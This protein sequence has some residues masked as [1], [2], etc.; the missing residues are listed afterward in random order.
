MI[1]SDSSTEESDDECV[2]PSYTN[3]VHVRGR[4]LSLG[5]QH[6]EVKLVVRKAMNH[7]LE[8]LLFKDGFPSLAMRAIWS[9]RSFICASISLESSFGA[10]AQERYQRL[11]ERFKSDASYVREL[12]RLV[13]IYNVT[14][15][16][17]IWPEFLFFSWK[18]ASHSLVAT[19]RL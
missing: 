7:M 9:R 15:H 14:C 2:W 4:D 5:Q 8:F 12:S 10:S 11:T 19:S 16:F 6:F 18:L 17:I 13:C 3:I 1:E